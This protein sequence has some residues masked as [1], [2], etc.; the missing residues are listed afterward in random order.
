[1]NSNVLAFRRI[2]RIL[3]FLRSRKTQCFWY[4]FRF[5]M[6]LW[7]STLRKGNEFNRFWPSVEYPGSWI[8]YGAGKHNVFDTFEGFGWLYGSPPCRSV[9]D[10]MSA[11]HPKRQWIHR[12]LGSRR[13]SGSRIFYGVEKHNVFEGF[14]RLPE[15]GR[16]HVRRPPEKAMNS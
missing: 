12:V 4:I 13:I 3:D 5:R 11:A 9:D 15:R 2:S 10:T 14:W 7:Q 16:Y 6:T 1:M 8:F